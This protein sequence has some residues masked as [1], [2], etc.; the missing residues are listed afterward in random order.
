MNFI[1][2]VPYL[3]VIEELA[4]NPERFPVPILGCSDSVGLEWDPEMFLTNI[5]R[6]TEAGGAE[7]I[8]PKSLTHWVGG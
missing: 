1:S 4:T 7:T 5:P 8:F 6:D 2:E 3:N